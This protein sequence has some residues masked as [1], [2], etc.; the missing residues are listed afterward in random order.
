[1][2]IDL[3]IQNSCDHMV[4]WE[5]GSLQSDLRTIYFQRP[6]ASSASLTL[7]INNAVIESA[8]YAVQVRNDILAIEQPFSL[9]MARKIKDYQ[10]LIE[11][12]YV[13]IM[14]Y[15]RKCRGVGGVD[16]IIYENKSDARTC[17]DEELLLQMLEKAVVTRLGSNPFHSWFGT[18]LQDLVGKKLIDPE[19]AQ[20]RMNEQVSMAVEK[21]R[22]LQGQMQSSGREL[23]PR[24]LF[25]E[26][27]S[28][29]SAPSPVD[30]SIYTIRVRFT[31]QSGKL[32]QYD[33]LVN[34]QSA[35]TRMASSW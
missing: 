2:S 27:I 20:N 30:P 16:D 7:R 35:K 19:M 26:L 15:C 10:P 6:L 18:G 21:L 14:K 24:E 4:H 32:L 12:Q 8:L 1:M 34:L 28:L 11:A 17:K 25:G 5:V 29:E 22:T 33:Q 31:S 3:K 23:T 13:T 9:L